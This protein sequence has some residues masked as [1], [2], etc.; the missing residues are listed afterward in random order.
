MDKHKQNTDEKFMQRNEDAQETYSIWCFNR[1]EAGAYGQSSLMLL[2]SFFFFFFETWHFVLA[3]LALVYN[4]P[5]TILV[6]R[7]TVNIKKKKS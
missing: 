6:S 4:L 1:R 5:I 2:F 3:L 7:T